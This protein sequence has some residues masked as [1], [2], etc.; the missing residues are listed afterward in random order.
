MQHV[1][2]LLGV[3]ILGISILLCGCGEI[4]PGGA[5][6]H[7]PMETDA[8]VSEEVYRESPEPIVKIIAGEVTGSGVLYEKT[9]EEL[10]VVTAGHVLE[11]VRESGEMVEILLGD[12]DSVQTASYI[13]S[14]T[15]ETGFLCIPRKEIAEEKWQ[16]YQAAQ[17]DKARFDA[18]KDGDELVLK[19]MQSEAVQ[20]DGALSEA[21][22]WSTVE[23]N[24][25]EANA[26][27]AEVP[28]GDYVR[29]CVGE[30]LYPWIYIEDFAQYMMLIKGEC[31]PGMS[32]GG[33]FDGE[34]YLVGVLCG[35]NEAGE[36][37]AVPLNVIMAEY[38]QLV[39]R[40]EE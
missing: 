34:G 8:A 26:V 9:E 21:V 32:G 29:W 1:K 7:N 5:E 38:M 40:A 12:A 37:A 27:Q 11:Q 18:L 30:L 25:A 39:G 22:Q 33:V 20:A 35:V 15:S 4:S 19:G 16:Q 14:E 10:I 17:M 28:S 2:S 24:A 6:E 23:V 3:G 31:L 36:T 13:I